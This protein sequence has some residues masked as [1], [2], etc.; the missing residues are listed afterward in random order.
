MANIIVVSKK[1]KVE[2]TFA[3]KTC[4]WDAI[5]SFDDSIAGLLDE[6]PKAQRL[7]AQTITK[8]EDGKFCVSQQ[9]EYMHDESKENE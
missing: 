5:T 7:S 4:L 6:D 2:T 1:R 8:T 3:I 9:W